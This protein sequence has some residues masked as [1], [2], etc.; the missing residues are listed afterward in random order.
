M[1]ECEDEYCGCA[2]HGEL[3]IPDAPPAKL[4]TEQNYYEMAVELELTRPPLPGP[5]LIN[6]TTSGL[7]L[8][9]DDA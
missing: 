2:C 5:K 4:P 9:D 7:N 8:E 1:A 6:I 3:F